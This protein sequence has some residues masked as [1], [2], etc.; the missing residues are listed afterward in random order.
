MPIAV[1]VDWYGPFKSFEK[2][3]T[4]ATAG[5]LP[6]KI[7]YFGASY[8]NGNPD[9]AIVEY[10]GLST[11]P[12]SRF[13]N[14][15]KLKDPGIDAFYLGEITTKGLPGRRS[16]KFPDDL[17]SAERALIAT[18]QPKRNLQDK[19]KPLEDCIVVFSRFFGKNRLDKPKPTPCWFKPVIAYNSFSEEWVE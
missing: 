2:F 19:I 8:Q 18:I 5:R 11:R 4:E 1:I 17:R 12:K 9:D 16:G 15:P 14:H 7:L 3:K 6:D 10:I 13:A